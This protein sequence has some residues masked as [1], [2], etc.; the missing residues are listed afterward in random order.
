[1]TKSS[2]SN[3]SINYKKSKISLFSNLFYSIALFIKLKI[4]YFYLIIFE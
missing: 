3:Y 4:Y 2:F 1:M